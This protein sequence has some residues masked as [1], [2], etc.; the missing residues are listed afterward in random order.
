MYLWRDCERTDSCFDLTHG[1]TQYIIMAQKGRKAQTV[2]S[3]EKKNELPA[4]TL[5]NADGRATRSDKR[6]GT[7]R[8]E[9]KKSDDTSGGLVHVL[10]CVVSLAGHHTKWGFPAPQERIRD[11]YAFCNLNCNQAGSPEVVSCLY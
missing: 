7:V 10:A 9:G 6:I 4:G 5:R 2:G 8:K 11:V 3:H 1:A